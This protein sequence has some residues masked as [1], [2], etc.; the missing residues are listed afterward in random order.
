MAD[1][2]V[3]NYQSAISEFIVYC[4]SESDEQKVSTIVH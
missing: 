4:T 3:E 1:S 2:H